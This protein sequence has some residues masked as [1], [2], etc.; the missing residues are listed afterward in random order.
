MSVTQGER[1]PPGNNGE[2]GERGDYVSNLKDTFTVN[3]MLSD[4]HQYNCFAVCACFR[5]NLE[6]TEIAAKE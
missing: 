3:V 5:V 2:K 4:L 1:G 6:S